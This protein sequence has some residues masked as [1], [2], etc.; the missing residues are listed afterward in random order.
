[1]VLHTG[2]EFGRAKVPTL[3]VHPQGTP[4]TEYAWAGYVS[5]DFPWQ[6]IKY[7]GEFVRTRYSSSEMAMAWVGGSAAGDTVN[8]HFTFASWAM[9]RKMATAHVGLWPWILGVVLEHILTWLPVHDNICAAV[10]SMNSVLSLETAMNCTSVFN[11]VSPIVGV[12]WVLIGIGKV[13]ISYTLK[14]E[15]VDWTITSMCM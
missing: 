5:E 3:A 14:V 11:W 7:E 4:I 2:R 6:L 1:M 15:V 13:V 10:S 8:L 12:S 9:F